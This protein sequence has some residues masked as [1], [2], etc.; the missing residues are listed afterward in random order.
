[1]KKLIFTP[2]LALLIAA[3]TTAPAQ[4][5]PDEYLGLPGDNLNLY[6]VMKLF[7]ESET[8]EGFERNLNDENSRINNLDLNGDNLIDFITVHDYVDGDVHTIVLRVALNR[9]EFQD[10]AVFTVEKIRDGSVHI[11]L[12]GDEAL[13]GKNYI[14]EPIY[15]ETPNP[16]YTGTASATRRV[17]VTVVR[18]TPYEV[19]AWPVITYIYSPRYV[20]W[21]SAW[22]WGYYPSYWRPWRPYYWHYYYGYHYNWYHHYYNHYRHWPHYRYPRYTTYYYTTVRV[23]S[24]YVTNSIRDGQY[25]T[26]YSRPEQRRAG[27]ALFAEVNPGQTRR[28]ADNTPAASARREV[29]REGNERNA[30]ANSTTRRQAAENS[31]RAATRSSAG[32]NAGTERRAATGGTVRTAPAQ[33]SSTERRAATSGTVRTAPAQNS[34]T[35]RRAAPAASEKAATGRTTPVQN[36]STER[37][38]A[39]AASEKAATGRTTPV[40]NNSTERRAAPA[41]SEKAATGRTAPAQKSSTVRSAPAT[42]ASKSAAKPATAAK[43]NSTA[44]SRQ[45]AATARSQQTRTA[46]E[47]RQARSSERSAGKKESTGSSNS[48]RK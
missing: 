44:G 5:F 19:A 20:V 8:L 48:R 2:I 6:A 12:V 15:N 7:Q 41:A 43:S 25:R 1:M 30:A 33:N 14:I 24:T 32:Q 47:S 4:D 34:N 11:Q 26:T 45:P 22:Y 17:N 16:G 39:P 46:K 28:T 37:R 35:E 23:H 21:R 18:T 42:A 3:G 10:V 31:D 13:Y 9:N 38:A 40:Q 29:F 27:E 36:N